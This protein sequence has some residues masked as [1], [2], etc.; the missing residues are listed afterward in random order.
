MHTPKKESSS[1]RSHPAILQIT[2]CAVLAVL[3]L[4]TGSATFATVESKKPEGLKA[5]AT[6]TFIQQATKLR[7]P[8]IANQGQIEDKRVKYYTQTFSGPAY[9]TENGD[10]GY[11]F[12]SANSSTS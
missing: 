5:A 4:I 9:V 11:R 1:S 8:F 3:L 2:L 12:S 7:I 10:I 6:P